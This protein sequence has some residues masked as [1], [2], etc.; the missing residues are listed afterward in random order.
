[1][2]R[3]PLVLAP[4]VALFS[5]AAAS[6]PPSKNQVGDLANGI[7]PPNVRDLQA[8]D[9]IVDD[10]DDDARGPWRRR[11][12][13]GGGCTETEW[14]VSC[15]NDDD[16]RLRDLEGEAGESARAAREQ[17]FFDDWTVPGSDDGAGGL[18]RSL[19]DVT[20]DDDD[21]LFFRALRRDANAGRGSKSKLDPV[22]GH[23]DKPVGGTA[24][25]KLAPR[26]LRGQR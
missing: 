21:D 6:H 18:R 25:R 7:R 1:M 15:T 12:L 22:A 17:G 23:K 24:H 26:H 10:D 5:A 2:A 13:E 4:L 14:G 20:Q 16:I 9:W 8:D 3:L 11:G 19:E